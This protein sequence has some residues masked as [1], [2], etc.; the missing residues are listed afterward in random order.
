VAHREFET[1][2]GPVVVD[3]RTLA[4]VA[5][6]RVVSVDGPRGSL[7]HVR[8]RPAHVEVLDAEGRREV[9]EIRDVQR[10]VIATIAATAGALVIAMRVRRRTR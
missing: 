3:G 10:F 7:F 4:L 5:K 9:I 1:T 6:N 8:S 2:T